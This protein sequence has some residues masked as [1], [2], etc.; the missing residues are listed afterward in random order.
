[1]ILAGPVVMVLPI[2]L[3]ELHESNDA[4]GTSTTSCVFVVKLKTASDNQ[5]INT[6]LIITKLLR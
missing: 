4:L 2:G 1:M 6:K 5:E 3:A